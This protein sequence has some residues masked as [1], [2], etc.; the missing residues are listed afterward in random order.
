MLHTA[1]LLEQIEAVHER[2]RVTNRVATRRDWWRI[3]NAADDATPVYIYDEIGWFGLTA[4]DFLAQLSAIDTPRITLHL[5]SPGGEVF[6]GIAIYSTLQQHPAHVD[7]IIDSLAASITSVIAMAGDTLTITPNGTMM[8]HDAMGL[9]VGNAADHRDL[10]ELLDKISDNI[11]SIYAQRTGS[12]AQRNVDKWRRAMRA[13]TWY[14]AK[15]ALAAGL[16]DRIDT[17][18]SDPGDAPTP[19]TD[20][21][22]VFDLS[23]FGFDQHPQFAAAVSEPL[24]D[25]N[26]DD[27]PVDLSPPIDP[28]RFRAAFQEALKQ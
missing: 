18:T 26:S 24:P 21:A 15:E 27:E 2:Y 4:T 16:V 13:E 7:V 14:S 25:D 19:A 10:A 6:D 8:I 11:A 1:E 3:D 28:A 17:P 12:V 20:D 22:D 23:V 5:N 9:A